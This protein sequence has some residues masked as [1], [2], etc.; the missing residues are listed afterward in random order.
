MPTALLVDRQPAFVAL[1]GSFLPRETRPADERGHHRRHVRSGASVRARPRRPLALRPLD[2]DGDPAQLAIPAE[3]L[4]RLTA[5][6]LRPG[7]PSADIEPA[8]GVT[9]DEL[10]TAFPGY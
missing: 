3:A 10:R 7:W 9:M 4:V 6:R 2:V 1:V 8:G 5:G